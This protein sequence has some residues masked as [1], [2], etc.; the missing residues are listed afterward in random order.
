MSVRYLFRDGVL[1][2]E[3]SHL[4]TFDEVSKG[5]DFMLVGI[6]QSVVPMERFIWSAYKMVW[7]EPNWGW[8]SQPKSV[9]QELRTLLL[10]QKS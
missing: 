10:L 4:R 7:F 8:Q 2:D 9:I 3:G 5:G 6:L 1:I